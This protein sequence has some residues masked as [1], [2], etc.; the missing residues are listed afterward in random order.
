VSES[1]PHLHDAD[2]ICGDCWYPQ[3][4][5]EEPLAQWEIDLLREAENAEQGGDAA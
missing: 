4:A 3:A 2:C 5:S 1:I